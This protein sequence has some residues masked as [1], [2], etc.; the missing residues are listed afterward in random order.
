MWTLR[1]LPDLS[2][3]LIYSGRQEITSLDKWP[4]GLIFAVPHT[5]LVTWKVED[6]AVGYLDIIQENMTPLISVE[7]AWN[8]SHLD[9]PKLFIEAILNYRGKLKPRQ[10]IRAEVVRT[11]VEVAVDFELIHK[12]HIRFAHEAIPKWHRGMVVA[13]TSTQSTD[14]TRRM[15]FISKKRIGH[16]TTT[17][18]ISVP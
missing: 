15:P 11:H 4:A 9:H 10:I 17:R 12:G 3:F 18:S 8:L 16:V 1:A 13:L 5:F 14:E 7:Q 2:Q 6:P